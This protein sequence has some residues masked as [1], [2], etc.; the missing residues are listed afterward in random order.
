MIDEPSSRIQ[1]EILLVCSKITNS[2]GIGRHALSLS[3][4]FA[5]AGF[6]VLH[7]TVKPGSKGDSLQRFCTRFYMRHI[8]DFGFMLAATWALRFRYSSHC[9]VSPSVICGL[10]T[11]QIHFSSCHLH[12]LTVAG[13]RWKLAISPR[14]LF[15]VVAEFYQYKRC[16]RAVFISK[17]QADQFSGYYGVRK[18]EYSILPP[19]LNAV[20]FGSDHVD[21]DFGHNYFKNSKRKCLFIGYN[22]RL[23]GL[24]IAQAAISHVEGELDIIGSDARYKP[25]KLEAGVFRFLGSLQFFDINWSEYG[26][27]IF[28]SHS[29]SYAFVI[30]EAVRNGL[31]PICSSQA[32]GSEVLAD[33]DFDAC[34]IEQKPEVKKEDFESIAR[35][36]SSAINRW[37]A[38]GDQPTELQINSA[39]IYDEVKYINNVVDNL[40]NGENSC[41]L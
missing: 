14:N 35:D 4:Q 8:F 23:K 37:W 32:G 13:E 39:R 11:D 7:F 3:E 27:F 33:G 21:Q 31:I 5:R 18:K 38:L 22:F 1:K 34:V 19:V 9:S 26:F 25:V 6:N 17:Q 29:D 24:A 28:P 15:Y 16:K 30:Q 10:G 41:Q 2:D 36:Y 40:S 20:N 12:S